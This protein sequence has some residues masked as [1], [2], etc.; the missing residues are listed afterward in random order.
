MISLSS[1]RVLEPSSPYELASA[2]DLTQLRLLSK[3]CLSQTDRDGRSL[4]HHAARNGHLPVLEYLVDSGVSLDTAD[5]NGNTAL[6]VA[7]EHV[8]VMTVDLLLACGAND[9]LLNC[10]GD[11]PI[12]AVVRGGSV[13]LLKVFVTHSN[14]NL[15][16]TDGQKQTVLHILAEN[17]QAGMAR[18]FM[19]SE[20]LRRL[21][22]ETPNSVLSCPDKDG[23][24]PLHLA[25]SKNTY[26]VLD[27]ILSTF[28][29]C[30]L[31]VK[32]VLGSL[33]NHK[34]GGV[35]YMAVEAGNVEAVRVLLQHGASPLSTSATTEMP[36]P[37]HLACLQ[38]RLDVV[39]A[40]VE[41]SDKGVLSHKDQR[42]GQSVL[43]YAARGLGC[44]VLEY[45]LGTTELDI[46]NP[47]ES[48]Q[49]PLHTAVV[50]GHIESAKLLIEH[51]ANPLLKDKKQRSVLHLAVVHDQ[52]ELLG[53]LLSLPRVTSL[54]Q[55]V[56]EVGDNPFHL[57]IKNNA[58]EICTALLEKGE[59]EGV[60]DGSGNH[61]LHLVSAAG[62]I[63][64]LTRFL[65]IPAYL[66]ALNDANDLGETPLHLA[67]EGGHFKCVRQLLNRGIQ[68]RW[69]RAGMTAFL[70]ACSH[71]HITT[72]KA[73]LDA[74]PFQLDWTTDRGDTALH[75]AAISARPSM[76]KF[77][78]DKGC[79]LAL[80][81]ASQSFLEVAIE[82][83]HLDVVRIALEH[84]R[85]QECLD[86]HMPERTHPMLLCICKMPEAAKLILDQS[87]EHASLDKSHPDYWE[88]FDFKYLRPMSGTPFRSN[89]TPAI[90]T[91]ATTT[92]PTRSSSK[93]KGAKSMKVVSE[94]VD[95][96]QTDLLNHPVINMYIKLKWNK[97]GF[98]MYSA[99]FV[100]RLLLATFISV[101]TTLVL[102]SAAESMNFNL[103]NESN[104]SAAAEDT[105]PEVSILAQVIRVIALLINLVLFIHLLYPVLS[106]GLQI[107]NFVTNAP[108]IIYFVTCVSNFVFLLAPNPPS[109]LPAGAVA[110][111][112]SWL[113]VLI[114]L[115]FFDI[116]GIYIRMFLRVTRTLFTV[117]LLS[118]FLILAFTFSF[119]V[120]V[121]TVDDFSTVQ[122]SLVSVYFYMLGEFQQDTL[123][124]QDIE[125]TLRNRELAF[126]FLFMISIL[127]SVVM[128]NMIIGLAVG[129]IEKI[130]RNAFVEKQE[131]LIVY[132]NH[133][134]NIRC[135][136]R[137]E[138]LSHIRYP[139]AKVSR[140]RQVWR[141]IWR[142]TKEDAVS[143]AGGEI[144]EEFSRTRASAVSTSAE[145]KLT[146]ITEQLDKLAEMVHILQAQQK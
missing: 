24:S 82:R 133:I 27:M 113:M 130:K 1:V 11:A 132:F 47:D 58:N 116:F 14:I 28:K 75:Y 8:Q 17:D 49:T 84:E 70:H 59:V 9:T 69:C 34:R 66:S 77:L 23:S 39:R 146:R 44:G 122:Y 103:S 126:I 31:S 81:G 91:E 134:D 143:S 64:M 33:E 10:N 141:Y 90:T 85:W 135:L 120:L 52:L 97:Y 36:C 109:I 21:V 138:V 63:T 61:Y 15:L 139:N 86:C 72:A 4:L 6:H 118:S 100:L 87:Y 108:L 54:R 121:D 16:V 96:G 74:F 73:L 95:L 111:F 79:N 110:C 3:P 142:A 2:G 22:L 80:N 42:G 104:S 45:V 105:S 65:K 92:T 19:N 136:G 129:D 119:H 144:D 5:K 32:D 62:N 67:A 41:G 18:A 117:L 131:M 98:W 46:D 89:G 106:V 7:V 124:S 38:G 12:H 71:G 102:D 78:L 35:L 115:G 83:G 57:A 76:V 123:I 37:L 88:R 48:G 128:A 40:M 125:G 68:P 112:F 114:A 107:L 13:D 94:M 50:Y 25:A 140:I 145:E 93:K 55:E 51:M 30:S 26:K 43:H 137:F 101:F 53:Y 56:D 29:S 127:L 60:K 99:I 20:P